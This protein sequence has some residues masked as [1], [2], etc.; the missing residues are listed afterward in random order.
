MNGRN[1]VF[2]GSIG[3]YQ[4]I[5]INNK[6][7][8]GSPRTASCVV[9]APN[10]ETIELAYK[11]IVRRCTMRGLVRYAIYTVIGN[12]G[13]YGKGQYT[14]AVLFEDDTEVEVKVT[15]GSPFNHPL[16]IQRYRQF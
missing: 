1:K 6:R 8:E 9:R 2:F 15:T 14:I 10:G 7:L 16:R 5:D 11:E 13:Q 4:D 12:G 3:T